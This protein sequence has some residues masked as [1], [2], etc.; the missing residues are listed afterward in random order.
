MLAKVFFLLRC[1]LA[2]PS[3]QRPENSMFDKTASDLIRRDLVCR[4]HERIK[5]VARNMLPLPISFA[6]ACLI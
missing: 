6:R 4:L 5:M 3:S 2:D 1:S